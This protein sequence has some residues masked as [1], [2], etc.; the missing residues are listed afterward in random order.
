MGKAGARLGMWF[1]AF[2][3]RN[4]YPSSVS[5]SFAKPGNSWNPAG[6]G[7]FGGGPHRRAYPFP[8]VG[9][10]SPD[11]VRDGVGRELRHLT[12][13]LSEVHQEMSRENFAPGVATYPHC[14]EIYIREDGRG[15]VAYACVGHH[16]DVREAV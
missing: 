9:E 6:S 12:E 13:S 1:S 8:E 15:Y 3:V 16:S 5:R 2:R 11:A 7:G 14:G 4:G 10:H